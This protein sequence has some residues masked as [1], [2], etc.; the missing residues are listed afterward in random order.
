MIKGLFSVVIPVYNTQKYL[1]RCVNSVLRQCYPLFEIILVDDG[2]TDGSGTICDAYGKK[3]SCCRVIHQE[4]RGLSA[5]RNSGIRAAEGEYIC[6]VDSDDY[7]EKTL[8]TRTAVEMKKGVDLCSFAVRRVDEDENYLYEMRF[9]NCIGTGE[10]TSESRESF[11]L[12]HFFSYELGWEACFQ[13]YRS[14]LIK[15]QNLY[16]DETLKFGEDKLFNFCYWQYVAK[17]TK[18]PDVLYN[19][20][21]RLGSLSE[22]KSEL[23]L[24]N[25]GNE[26]FVYISRYIERERGYL[27]YAGIVNYYYHLIQKKYSWEEIIEAI[28]LTRLQKQQWEQIQI[29]VRKKKEIIR[30]S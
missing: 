30:L 28:N 11:V 26:E 4:N 23:E 7:I 3:Y 8:L 18:I 25:R 2:S 19:Y 17:W 9:N 16:F 14:D 29:L 21:L 13:I 24:V 10:L 5:A 1:M 27:Y 15:N 20:T 22:G 6:F 12:N